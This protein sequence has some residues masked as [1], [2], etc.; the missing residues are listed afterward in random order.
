MLRKLSNYIIYLLL[1]LCILIIISLGCFSF[2]WLNL[3]NY[4]KAIKIFITQQIG[5]RVDFKEING[6]IDFNLEPDITLKGLQVTDIKTHI[7]IIVINKVFM[8]LSFSSLLHLE[9]ILAK[10][11]INGTDLNIELDKD[12]NISLNKY[13]ITNLDRNKAN[14]I[15]YERV[16][17]N[18]KNIELKNLNIKFIDSKHHLQPLELN[19]FNLNLSNNNLLNSHN[20]NLDCLLGNKVSIHGILKQH[21]DKLLEFDKWKSANFSLNTADESG[22]NITAFAKVNHYKLE[23]LNLNLITTTQQI[24]KIDNNISGDTLLSGIISIK[25]NDNSGYIINGDKLNINTSSGNILENAKLIGEYKNGSGILI[26]DQMNLNGISSIKMLNIYDKYK[27]TGTFKNIKYQFTDGIIGAKSFNLSAVLND[28]NAN[29]LLRDYPSINNLYANINLTNNNAT[30]VANLDNAK[31]TYPKYLQNSFAINKALFNINVSSPDN[32]YLSQ[33]NIESSYINNSDFKLSINSLIN[34][35]QKTL[36]L[37]AKIKTFDLSNISK[38]LPL[39]LGDSQIKNIKNNILSGKLNNTH[40]TI[41]SKFDQIPES[42]IVLHTDINNLSYNLGNKLTTIKDINARLYLINDN[43]VINS[44]GFS[45][46]DYKFDKANLNLSKLYTNESVLDFRLLGSGSTQ[47]LINLIENSKYKLYLGNSKTIQ[48]NGQ[49][50]ITLELKSLLNNFKNLQLKAKIKLIENEIRFN[51]NYP[52]IYGINGDIN[53][54]QNGVMLSYLNGHMLD[55]NL[56][57]KLYNSDQLEVLSES[58]D[59]GNLFNYLNNKNNFNDES[60]INTLNT[61]IV[62]GYSDLRLNYNINTNKLDLYSSLNGVA[63]NAPTLLGKQA[64]ETKPFAI[65]YQYNKEHNMNLIHINYLNSVNGDVALDDDFNIHLLKLA[66][67]KNIL[68]NTIDKYYIKANVNEIKVM[69]WVDF[70]NKLNANFKVSEIADNT[71]HGEINSLACKKIFFDLNTKAIWLDTYNIDGGNIHGSINCNII[72]LNFDLPAIYGKVNYYIANNFVN[73]NLNKL[74]ISTKNF[75][76]DDNIKS[77]AIDFNKRK[78]IM[79]ENKKQFVSV[80]TSTRKDKRNSALRHVESN[81]FNESEIYID[82]RDLNS[83]KIKIPDIK[84]FIKNLYLEN[85]YAGKFQANVV[86]R[87]NNLYIESASINNNSSDTIFRIIEHNINPNGSKKHYTDLRLQTN[88]KNLGELFAKLN[89]G[90]DLK[91]GSGLLDVTLNWGGGIKDFNLYH[92]KGKIYMNVK[93]GVFSQIKPGLLGSLFGVVSLSSITHASELNLNAFFGHSL[94]FDD[95]TTNIDLVHNSLNIRD[96]IITTPSAKIKSF[97]TININTMHLDSYLTIEPRLSATVATTAGIV[98]LNPVIGAFV[99]A[100]AFIV[101]DPVNKLLAISYHITGN[102]DQPTMK[103][104]D[105]NDQIQHNLTSSANI[106]IDDDAQYN[107]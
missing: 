91:G 24:K 54:N 38:Y 60:N 67:G 105:L 80:K 28:F 61:Q 55:S 77:T 69:D 26:L 4:Q 41:N 21:G 73:I 30:I 35:N 51:K 16:L 33:I 13:V 59:Y 18:Q 95:W 74:I 86:Q 12:N 96:L 34:L 43:L 52:N 20:I 72:D 8:R 2:F 98:T 14:T 70:I 37:D 9:P 1:L 23:Y 81:F 40:L 15:D 22:H 27:F 5:L 68:P 58:F 7:P 3:G 65:D 31:I 25:Q 42:G 63:I 83:P 17:L 56:I 50:Q 64:L 48:I 11:E 104:V 107:Y 88:I 92:N 82:N 29:A 47:S 106:G 44:T 78:Q 45:L 87:N 39:S 76:D 97:G 90:D 94:N 84:I 10:L 62:K 93:K 53:F 71:H 6:E 100:A 19:K 102:V 49:N 101:G 66:I 32:K 89:L 46:G 85:H 99:Y 79:Q 36:I 103:K 57:F 75:V